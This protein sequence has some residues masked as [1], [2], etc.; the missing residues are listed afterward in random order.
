M[1]AATR[2]RYETQ[3]KELR[4]KIK[5]WEVD[6]YKSHDGSKP[7]RQDIKNNREMGT[8]YSLS[9]PPPGPPPNPPGE[10]TCR[11]TLTCSRHLQ[12]IP[13]APRHTRRQGRSTKGRP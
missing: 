2:E 9:D 8:L 12:G 3:S 4:V 13:K 10:A 5:T 6:F 11:L 7:S 1:D